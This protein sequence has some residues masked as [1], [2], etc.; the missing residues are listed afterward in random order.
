MNKNIHISLIISLLAFASCTPFFEH[1]VPGPDKSALGLA[2]GAALGTGAGAAAAHHLTHAAG[3]E[4][5]L[6]GLGFGSIYGLVSGFSHDLIEENQLYRLDQ[7]QVLRDMIWA[8]DLLSQHYQRR[9]ELH[10]SRD[11]FPADWFFDGDSSDLK[12]QAEVLVNQIASLTQQRMPWSRIVIASYS[13]SVDPESTYSK[14]INR[15]R[16]AKIARG[17]VV[18]GVEPRRI[19]TKSITMPDPVLVDP[20][21]DPARYKQAIEIIPL[22][23]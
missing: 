6:I 8:Q 14:Y 22:D 3:P 7:Q 16:A 21:D 17:F 19:F 15:R 12:P 20:H 1:P 4:G 5:A 10:P 18:S 23:Y 9:I 11:I 13:T 2:T